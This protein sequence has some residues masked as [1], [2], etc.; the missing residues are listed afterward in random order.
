M[1]LIDKLCKTC[2]NCK[3]RGTLSFNYPCCDCIRPDLGNCGIFDENTTSNVMFTKFCPIDATCIPT[4]YKNNKIHR[5]LDKLKEVGLITGY[6]IK[7]MYM[8]DKP[9]CTDIWLY[10]GKYV[11]T[12]TFNYIS[13]QNFVITSLAECVIELYREMAN[14][15][16]EKIK[17][18]E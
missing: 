13:D 10:R 9:Y 3:Y 7:S 1:E 11:Y 4:K 12:Q 14:E 17:E 5:Y 8:D 15:L 18:D 16:M 6:D 2:D